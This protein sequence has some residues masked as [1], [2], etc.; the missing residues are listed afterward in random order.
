LDFFILD[1]NFPR[2][3]ESN[4]Y[5]QSTNKDVLM[6]IK[7]KINI[8]PAAEFYQKYFPGFT[9]N[10]KKEVV[11]FCP[12]H[13]D[14]KKPNLSIN[15]ETGKYHCFSCGKSGDKIQF[16]MDKNG[17]DFKTAIQVIA[18]DFEID[19]SPPGKSP[20][21]NK[22]SSTKEQQKQSLPPVPQKIVDAYVTRLKGNPEAIHYLEEKRGISRAIQEKYLLGLDGNKRFTIP[23]FD[24]KGTIRNVRLYNPLAGEDEAKMVS[25][26]KG[27][28]EARLY[29][30]DQLSKGKLIIC[31]GETDRNCLLSHLPKDSELGVIT[32]TGGCQKWEPEWNSQFYG[33]EVVIAYDN[34]DKGKESGQKVASNLTGMAISIKVIEWPSYFK[35]KEDVTDFFVTYH[36]KWLD[37]EK[38]INEAPEKGYI[39]PIIDEGGRYFIKT[40]KEKLK[41]ISNFTINIINKVMT[42]EG[43]FRW[44]TFKNTSGHNCAPFFLEPQQMASKQEFSKLCFSKGN[45]IYEGSAQNLT[46]IWK[47]LLSKD[48]GQIVYQPDHI[49][50]IEDGSWLFADCMITSSGAIISPDE[51]GIFWTEDKG[52]RPVSLWT[53]EGEKSADNIPSIMREKKLDMEQFLLDFRKS[54]GDFNAWMG[55]GW[56]VAVLFSREIIKQ[57]RCFPFL[58]ITGQKLAGKSTFAR[59]LMSFFGI[60]GGGKRIE[61]TTNNGLARALSYYSSLPVWLEEYRNNKQVHRKDGDLRGIY[62]RQGAMKG[63]THAHRIKDLSVR[64]VVL[65]SG[66]ETPADNALQTRCVVLDLVENKRNND[67]YNAINEQSSSFPSFVFEILK[68]KKEHIPKVLNGISEMK[69]LLHKFNLDERIEKNCAIFA[70]AF[71]ALIKEDEEFSAW[72]VNEAQRKKE[73]NEEESSVSIFW[74]QVNYLCMSKEIDGNFLAIDPVEKKLFVWFPGTYKRVMESLR[75]ANQTLFKEKVIRNYLKQEPYFFSENHL[76]KMAN[77]NPQRCMAFDKTKAPDIVERIYS[78]FSKDE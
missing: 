72:V 17:V 68:H 16:Y 44:V 14:K 65:L 30:L 57:Y 23:I 22:P 28:G 70:G 27:Y 42:P 50:L 64:G 60:E 62:D 49:G 31:E 52:Y 48:Q 24:E 13:D 75:R 40:G 71:Q 61:E 51:N 8:I 54:V 29:S 10:G 12:F 37:F 53:N 46:D 36:Q 67:L 18:K 77:G 59:W 7:E 55:L 3:L 43:C 15:T 25:Y 4:R 35:N 76:K 1:Q 19:N 32:G 69:D 58:F 2:G 21:K 74:D 33:K 73:E 6:D 45:F 20:R 34:D 63:T 41:A 47:L 66:Q 39:S 56:V 5:K 38:L 26:K 9:P 78:F 11:C